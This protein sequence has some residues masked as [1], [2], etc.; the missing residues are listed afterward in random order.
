MSQLIVHKRFY[1]MFSGMLNISSPEGI[2]S[3]FLSN[4]NQHSIIYMSDSQKKRPL[5][6]RKDYE[7][8]KHWFGFYNGSKF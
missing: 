1:H 5:P 6:V 7:K 3:Y 4:E 2:I 8:I